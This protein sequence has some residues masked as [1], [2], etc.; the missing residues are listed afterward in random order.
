[1]TLEA[2][3]DKYTMQTLSFEDMI[4]FFNHLMDTYEPSRIQTLGHFHVQNIRDYI[5]FFKE[6]E[7]QFEQMT[8][9]VE[10]LNNYIRFKFTRHFWKGDEKPYRSDDFEPIRIKNNTKGHKAF[11]RFWADFSEK[12]V[13]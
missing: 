10:S 11:L 6:D 3:N 12:F 4:W 1:M 8:C 7:G 13:K 9:H 5:Y 2:F